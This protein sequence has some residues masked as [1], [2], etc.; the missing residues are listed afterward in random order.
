MSWNA[1]NKSKY[2]HLLG[3]AQQN[4]HKNTHTRKWTPPK[5]KNTKE[6]NTQKIQPHKKRTKTKQTNETH[7]QKHE[8]Y[9]HKQNDETCGNISEFSEQGQMS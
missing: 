7:T 8:H 4:T 1:R 5:N 6:Q 9:N 3:G 2:G